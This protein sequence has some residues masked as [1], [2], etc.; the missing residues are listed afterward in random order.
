MAHKLPKEDLDLQCFINIQGFQG[1]N[2]DVR[3]LTDTNVTIEEIC[4]MF[5][6]CFD[7]NG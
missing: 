7:K 3:T 5:E 2:R 6:P 4:A 1:T